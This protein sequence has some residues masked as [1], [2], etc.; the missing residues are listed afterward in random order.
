MSVCGN[1]VYT[2]ASL[3]QAYHL[4]VKTRFLQDSFCCDMI[5]FL[6][7]PR[8]EEGL[9]TLRAGVEGVLALAPN[10]LLYRASASLSSH[11]MSCPACIL[12]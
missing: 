9:K 5:V 8:G 10:Q 2:T 7:L 4:L 12:A 3:S 11:V 1:A 6:Q